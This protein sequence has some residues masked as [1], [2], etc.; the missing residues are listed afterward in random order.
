MSFFTKHGAILINTSRGSQI[1]GQLPIQT[2]DNRTVYA[3]GPDETPV[4]PDQG[5]LPDYQ[6]SIMPS[7][8]APAP[9]NFRKEIEI[10]GTGNILKFMRL[11]YE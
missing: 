10:K 11:Y 2:L 9:H 5:P 7:P 1:D 3:A 8:V 6:Q 4:K